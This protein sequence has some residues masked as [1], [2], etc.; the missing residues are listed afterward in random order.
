MS[1]HFFFILSDEEKALLKELAKQSIASTLAGK[2]VQPEKPQSSKLKEKVGAFVT[3]T[4]DGKL[5]GCIGNLQVEK[6]LYKNVWHMAR[7]AAFK[8]SRFPVLSQEE[9]EKIE[10]EISVLSPITE[11]HD[12]NAI[13]VGRHG[14][15]VQRGAQSG[16]LLPQVATA[17]NWNQEQFIA[18]TCRKAGLEPSVINLAGTHV[19]WFE[20][21]VF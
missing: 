19:F 15:I 20:A 10:I 2:E 13:E 14:L 3:L 16:L 8:D 9:F 7:S 12:L 17:W 21:V 1:R 4:L 6:E 11:C 18:Q 5:R